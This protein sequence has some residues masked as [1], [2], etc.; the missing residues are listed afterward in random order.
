MARLELRAFAPDDLDDAARLLAERHARHRTT[1]PTLPAEYEQP[2]AAR[3]LIEELLTPEASGA[4]AT[5]GGDPVGFV[6]GTP[7]ANPIW[8]RNVWV[9]TAAHAS[10]E[11]EAIR[12]MYAL[13]S[14]RWVEEG[15]RSHYAIV[16]SS[17]AEAV[18]A[19]FRLG[20]GHQHVHAV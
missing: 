9:E 11:P 18:D 5:R 4:I 8:G 17:D 16:P 3:G 10:R 19:W 2:D 20:F 13:A 7:K 14:A 15:R 12:D 1:E 6:L